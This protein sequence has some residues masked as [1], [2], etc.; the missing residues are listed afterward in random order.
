MLMLTAMLAVALDPVNER[1]VAYARAQ[2]G[3]KVGDGEC[4]TLVREALRSAGA[5]RRG[6][7]RGWGTE[8]ASLKDVQPGD[9]LQFEGALFLRRRLEPDGGESLVWSNYAH[10]S[11]IVSAVR[12]R[13]KGKGVVLAILHQNVG[14]AGAD[15]AEVKVVQQATIDPASLRRGRIRAF[16]PEAAQPAT[17]P[18]PDRE[19]L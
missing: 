2:V 5:A 17:P 12:R 11:A 7:G 10:H 19:G 15:E 16:R 1:V 14:A 9:V 8:L 3:R 13:G 18:P 4:S 6:R